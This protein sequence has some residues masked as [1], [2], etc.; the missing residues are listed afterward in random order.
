MLSAE[1]AEDI[2]GE[3]RAFAWVELANPNKAEG[4]GEVGQWEERKLLEGYADSV[5]KSHGPVTVA[6]EP[7][8]I[9]GVHADYR[10]C[11]AQSPGFGELPRLRCE[12]EGVVRPM[13]SV[14]EVD[15]RDRLAL[16]SEPEGCGGGVGDHNV[17]SV[18]ADPVGQARR[19]G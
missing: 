1:F 19:N 10:R 16:R 15:K 18:V 14:A 8:F 11:V 2:A 4:L 9:V 13:Q 6:D 5:D 7:R 3:G 12:V 17:K